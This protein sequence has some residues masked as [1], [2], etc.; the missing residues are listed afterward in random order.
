MRRF[1]SNRVCTLVSFLIVCFTSCQVKDGIVPETKKNGPV[2]VGISAGSA[3]TR[4]SLLSNGLS[5]VWSD[6][7]ELAVWAMNSSDTYTL[8]NQKFG[9]HASDGG[10]AFFTSQLESEMPAD[11]YTYYACYPAPASVNGTSAVFSIS[12][13]QD[14]K[15]SG[16]EDVLIADPVSYGALTPIHEPDDHD[17]MSM[18]LRHIMHHFRLFI[19]EG[20]DRLDGESIEKIVLTFPSEVVGDVVADFSNPDA[21]LSLQNGSNKV[22]LRLAE[23]LLPSTSTE[24][25]FADVVILPQTFEAAQTFTIKT[26]SAT[27]VATTDPVNLRGRTFEAG[28]STPVNVL[29]TDVRNYCRINVNIAA[30]HIGEDPTSITLTAP[31]GCR[32]GDNGSNVLV[33]S[34]PAGLPEHYSLELSYEEEEYYRAFS[35]QSI[36]VVYDCEHVT[37]SVDY[38]MPDMSSNF[39]T[40]I[41]LELPYLL[42][43]DFSTV[44]TFSSNDNYT[45]GSNA[46]S[47]S[48]GPFLGGW[49][50]GRIGGEAGKCIRIAA[51]RETS[52]RYGARVD[53]API[54]ALKKAANLRVHFDYGINSRYGGVNIIVDGDVG[55]DCWIGYVTT[56][57][58]LD[59]G[60]TTGTFED[61]NHINAHLF[62]G[63]YDA[64][65]EDGDFILHNVPTGL[66]RISWRNMSENRAGTTNTTNWF[67]LDNVRVSIAK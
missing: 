19:P 14:G 25:K 50:G 41:D 37:T 54:I 21:A 32:W 66:V 24:L 10:R 8:S 56:S 4:T 9:V 15:A 35:N 11:A 47:K 46:G 65:P 52:A 17:M 29:L 67:Y 34:D 7:D 48:Y 45:G 20:A 1:R 6:G 44:G 2:T 16:G 62:T 60:S 27:K 61:G 26:Y 5:T 43:E 13:V 55:Q 49:S 33:L 53:S 12:D 28:H 30:N 63:S 22:T 42:F 38:R 18:R 59:S 36:H 40:S 3:Q 39:F 23:P 64:T 57:D 58:V 51:R 31:E